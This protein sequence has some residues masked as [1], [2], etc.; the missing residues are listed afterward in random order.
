[1]DIRETNLDYEMEKRK[2]ANIHFL[3]NVLKQVL[4]L[5]IVFSLMNNRFLRRNT[6]LIVVNNELIN[7]FAEYRC[8]FVCFFDDFFL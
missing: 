7:K 8:Q 4:F 3:K 2:F 1:M 6:F 5:E